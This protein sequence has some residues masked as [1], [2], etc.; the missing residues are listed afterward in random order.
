[1]FQMILSIKEFLKKK[2]TNNLAWIFYI[3]HMIF[4]IKNQWDQ[5][6]SEDQ[7]HIIRT[8]IFNEVTLKVWRIIEN[9]SKSKK[10]ST[11]LMLMIQR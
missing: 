7:S 2:F 1:M 4:I 8:K 9:P 3:Y 6:T 5:L 11:K 10:K